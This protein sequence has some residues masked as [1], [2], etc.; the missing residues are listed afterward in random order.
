MR[1]DYIPETVWT[2]FPNSSAIPPRLVAPGEEGPL[3]IPL[4]TPSVLP[5]VWLR[6]HWLLDCGDSV[7]P[8]VSGGMLLAK[9]DRASWLPQ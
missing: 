2:A 5:S 8:F 7:L 6:K 1:E 4:W 3:L 9:D